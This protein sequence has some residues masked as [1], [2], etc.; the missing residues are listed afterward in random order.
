[1]YKVIIVAVIVTIIGLFILTKVDP[2]TSN[3]GVVNGE[4]TTEVSGDLVNV[5][6]TG[7]I[8]HT[9]NYDISPQST[10][11]DLIDMAG[12]T[13][14]NADPNSYIPTLVIGNHSAFYISKKAEIPEPIITE[15]IAKVNV[16]TATAD[17]LDEVGFSSSQAQAIV[18]YR[19]A[20]GDFE[21]LEDI[22]E[23]SGIGE[24]T[25]MA[26]RDKICLV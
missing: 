9:G 25:Y 23:V 14:E 20:N 18:D 24:K 16:N 3:S 6:I 11:K 4:T 12:G 22:M 15:D 19:N 2:T 13:T 21:A 26:T 17:E 10:L 1:M 5:G 7:Q 8:T